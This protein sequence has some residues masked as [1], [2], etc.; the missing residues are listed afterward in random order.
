VEKY[1]PKARHI[2][3]QIIG[4]GHG[5][6]VH[7]YERDSRIQ[8]NNQKL[9]EEAPATILR[10]KERADITETTRQA[11]E[12][13]NYRGAG[14][15]EYLY[16]PEEKRFY[17]IEMNT[18]VQVEHTVSEEVSVFD[19]IRDQIDVAYNKDIGFSLSA[20]QLTVH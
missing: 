11:I 18:R 4:D 20:V 7:L 8:R 12:Q 10:E 15:I 19:I 16:V 9:L 2:E 5:G 6:A 17:F 13:L 3:I 1:I 14:T